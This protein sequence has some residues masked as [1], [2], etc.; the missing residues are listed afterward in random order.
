MLSKYRSNITAAEEILHHFENDSKYVILLA[1]MQ[2]GKSLCYWNVAFEQL[3]LNE[4]DFVII[5]SGNRENELKKQASCKRE[6][7]NVYVSILREKGVDFGNEDDLADSLFSRIKIIWG[8]EL[9][10]TKKEDVFNNY[11]YGGG[12]VGSILFIW[13]ESHFGQSKTQHVDLFLKKIGISANNASSVS[14]NNVKILSVSATPFSEL[15][16]VFSGTGHEK[17]VVQMIPSPEY[18]GVKWYY[19]QNKINGVLLEDDD[20][21]NEKYYLNVLNRS[22][23]G[24][25]GGGGANNGKK[26]AIIRCRKPEMKK[27]IIKMLEKNKWGHCNYDMTSTRRGGGGGGMNQINSFAELEFPPVGRS[28][29]IFV[30]G[31]C[32]MGT[33]VPKKHVSFVMELCSQES[34]TDT[35]LQG[36]LGRMCG[37]AAAGSVEV[38]LPQTIIES[39]EIERY[40]QFSDSMKPCNIPHCAMN[41]KKP[42]KMESSPISLIVPIHIPQTSLTSFSSKKLLHD[43]IISLLYEFNEEKIINPN[44]KET[45]DEIKM[46]LENT[47]ANNISIT[48]KNIKRASSSYATIPEKII[49]SINTKKPI[50]LGVVKTDAKSKSKSNFEKIMMEDSAAAAILEKEKLNILV[51]KID[52]DYENLVRNDYYVQ[53]YVPVC[54]STKNPSSEENMPPATTHEEVFY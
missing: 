6:A 13:E 28:T 45:T 37:Y 1:Q 7:F 38:H 39:G 36:L 54:I 29:V 43:D 47:E 3:R 9:L 49:K 12:G 40:V 33:V 2:S 46:M 10:K 34:N 20:V 11:E 22:L 15:C 32:R 50:N 52:D 23:L 44:S 8:T 51:L 31:L 24:G 41:I 30:K 48:L 17:K 53:F 42:T 26:W 19:E 16:N 4:N 25:G 14:A 35:I 21:L 5:F 18:R 27:K